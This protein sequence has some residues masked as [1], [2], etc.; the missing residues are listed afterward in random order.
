MRTS[1]VLLTV[2]A[3]CCYCAAGP[4]N[5]TIVKQT[6]TLTSALQMALGSSNI[7]GLL[8][9]KIDVTP[10]QIQSCGN[11]R[12]DVATYYGIRGR[13]IDGTNNNFVYSL[14]DI[15]GVI[16][17]IQ[18]S[19]P[20]EQV[21]TVG[22]EY[23]QVPVFQKE[24]KDGVVSYVQTVYF[25]ADPSVICS[26][27]RTD[28]DTAGTAS[29]LRLQNGINPSQLIVAPLQRRD[30]LASGQY[31]NN[32]CFP[33][34]GNHTFSAVDTWQ[35]NNCK[36]II[37]LFLLHNELEE[38]I[39]FGLAWTGFSNS[40][41]SVFEHPPAKVI[42]TILGDAPACV[43]DLANQ[44]KLTTLHVLFVR[45][46]YSCGFSSSEVQ[47]RFRKSID[48][49]VDRLKEGYHSLVCFF[50]RSCESSSSSS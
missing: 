22:F 18:V 24:T 46:P 7:D 44:G 12:L 40:S 25:V 49:F 21:D 11:G 4:A 43:I 28:F 26:T 2:A 32:K 39:G 38:L 6:F 37:P 45:D 14:F 9:T 35:A 33:G 34:M 5:K 17:G 27:G 41:K 47:E 36:R 1:S 16:S 15:N 48:D 19:T 8:E 20:V 29:G 30:A 3:L 50:W 31:T 23:D 42:S 10:E 13:R